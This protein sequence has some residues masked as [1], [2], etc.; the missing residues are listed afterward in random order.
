MDYSVKR[1]KLSV[2]EEARELK[3]IVIDEL[4]GNEKSLS[5]Y[6]K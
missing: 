5:N 2:M 3:D 1:I 6:M 4:E